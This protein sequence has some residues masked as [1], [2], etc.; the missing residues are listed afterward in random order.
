M[1]LTGETRAGSRALG[2]GQGHLGFR[3]CQESLAK[4]GVTLLAISPT[5]AKHNAQNLVCLPCGKRNIR[6]ATEEPRNT[7]FTKRLCKSRH[8]RLCWAAMDGDIATR[9][10]GA[11]T[12][13]HH[14]D[15]QEEVHGSGYAW[16][17]GQRHERPRPGRLQRGHHQGIRSH[18]K[19]LSRKTRETNNSSMDGMSRL[20]CRASRI[21]RMHRLRCRT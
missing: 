18:R 19:P 14:H 13:G 9:A 21:D 15:E 12:K 7:Y 1:S 3:C 5:E 17:R 16:F 20:P 11:S 2:R 6:T 4:R 8:T 10:A